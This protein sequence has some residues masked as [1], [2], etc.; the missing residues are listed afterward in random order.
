MA[1][2]AAKRNSGHCQRPVHAKTACAAATSRSSS[3]PA[4][5]WLRGCHQARQGGLRLPPMTTPSRPLPRATDQSSTST[6]GA[7]N[8]LPLDRSL[9]GSTGGRFRLQLF[10]PSAIWVP[11]AGNQ[12]YDPRRRPPH[13]FPATREPVRLGWPRQVRQAVASQPR[14]RR[15]PHPFP[16][17]RPARQRRVA[18]LHRRQLFP[19]WLGRGQKYGLSS[20]GLS[21]GTGLLDNKRKFPV[22]RE[23]WID[24][25]DANTDRLTIYALPLG[26]P[27]RGRRLQVHLHARPRNTCRRRGQSYSRASP[28]DRV[29]LGAS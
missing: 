22:F 5:V 20:R 2:A 8:P 11:A 21:I 4:G 23:F 18:L 19:D 15:L 6:P 7:R 9:L 17:K 1:V 24:T 27:A 16:A 3:R 25:P 29:D 26:Q 28:I 10:H 13:R 12:Q 14:L